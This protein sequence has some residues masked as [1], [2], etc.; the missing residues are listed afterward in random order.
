M[1][2]STFHKVPVDI[3]LSEEDE[4]SV[5]SEV[6]YNDYW[7]YGRTWTEDVKK[8]FSIV[9]QYYTGFDIERLKR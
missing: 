4:I 2:L 7:D 3:E 8:S 6:L 5:V 1:K 9:Y